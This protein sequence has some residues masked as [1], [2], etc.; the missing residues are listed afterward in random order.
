MCITSDR[1]ELLVFDGRTHLVVE[2]ASAMQN[3]ERKLCTHSS[4][5]NALSAKR[6]FTRQ[7]NRR[8]KRRRHG[9]LNMVN[10]NAAKTSSSFPR[11]TSKADAVAGDSGDDLGYITLAATRRRK[12]SRDSSRDILSHSLHAPDMSQLQVPRNRRLKF[13]QLFGA[14]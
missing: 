7:R 12:G 3:K 11:C 5:R 13:G 1:S 14:A 8:P 9:N 10:L 6:S 2:F 4:A